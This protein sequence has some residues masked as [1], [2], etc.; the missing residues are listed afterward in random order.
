RL[1]LSRGAEMSAMVRLLKA[2]GARIHE[3]RP[4]SVFRVIQQFCKGRVRGN[5]HT[6]P[7]SGKPV[8]V[9]DYARRDTPILHA[10]ADVKALRRHK[11]HLRAAV[12]PKEDVRKFVDRYYRPERYEALRGKDTIYLA[13]PSTSGKNTIPIEFARRLKKDYG[14]EIVWNF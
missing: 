4:H 9:R 8:H 5:D 7:R 3:L 6:D 13:M 2:S 14:G 10:A 11:E 1:V 12:Y